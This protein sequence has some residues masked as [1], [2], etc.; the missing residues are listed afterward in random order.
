MKRICFFLLLSLCSS[1]FAANGDDAI[2]ARIETANRS[3]SSLQAP[4]TQVKT[5]ATKKTIQMNGTLYFSRADRMVMTYAQPDGNRFVINGGRMLVRSGK[6]DKIY[7]LSSTPSMQLLSHY[8]LYAMSGKVRSIVEE[9]KA[10]VEVQNES[11]SENYVITLKAATKQAKGFSRIT[12]EYSK[13]TGLLQRME[14][15]EFNHTVNTYSISQIKTGVSI[16]EQ[17]YKI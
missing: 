8:L 5:L 10:I 16:P 7:T 6:Q 3:V 15:E 12:L 14:M 11:S 2:L 1:I 17:V 13:K 4:F 9:N